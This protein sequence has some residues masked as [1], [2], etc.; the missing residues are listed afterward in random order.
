MCVYP[1]LV[2]NY[3]GQTAVLLA[4]PGL[5]QQAYWDSV[6]EA[7]REPRRMQ[8]A[9]A[10]PA[11]SQ[12]LPVAPAVHDVAYYARPA[13]VYWPMLV[14]A[15]IATV[16]ASQAL[17]T[18]SF[19]I[20]Q[21]AQALNVFPRLTIRHTSCHHK[22]QIYVPQVNWALMVGCVAVVAG[23]KTE[24]AIGHAYGAMQTS[25]NRNP[26][27]M[28]RRARPAMH[29]KSMQHASSR[30]PR[31]TVPMH[32]LNMCVSF[33][34]L[35]VVL[36]MLLSTWLATLCMLV[37]YNVHPLPAL[38]YFA[39]FT[40]AECA[41]LSSNAAKVPSGAWFPLV[42]TALLFSLAYI[43]H[44]GQSLK[45][46]TI[47]AHQQK[48][49]QLLAP[50]GG[51]KSMDGAAAPA[52]A[53]TAAQGALV[54]ADGTPVS[55]V[56]GVGIY[57]SELTGGVPPVMARF[58]TAVP[59]IHQVVVFL[60]VRRVPLP[61]VLEEEQLIL[62]K[63][64]LPGFYHAVLRAGYMDEVILDQDFEEALVEE[65]MAYLSSEV[66]GDAE[67][68]R[69]S[70]HGAGAREQGVLM[71]A[72]SMPRARSPYVRSASS[73]RALHRGRRPAGR[74]V[75]IDI[76]PG[77]G[78]EDDALARALSSLGAP[79]SAQAAGLRLTRAAAPPALQ[80]P[81][82]RWPGFCR[83]PL[84]GSRTRRRSRR[85][86][87]CHGCSSHR[88]TCACARC[89][90]AALALARAARS[91]ARCRCRRPP[92]TRRP[93]QPPRKRQSR[94]RA[95]TRRPCRLPSPRPQAAR[96]PPAPPP[97]APPPSRSLA[98]SS[99]AC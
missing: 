44:W 15:T 16:V 8:D 39:V 12:R 7:V 66:A 75:A 58:L 65:L 27:S 17:I 90:P 78:G 53:P 72:L 89:R 52:A 35:A 60:T 6:P 9:L 71:A 87:R 13:Q 51:R 41:F 91:P 62:R 37:T 81:S 3:L 73:L 46:A 34:G 29:S 25:R 38:V 31:P 23:F 69:G 45:S 20:A 56:P 55:R 14:I 4:R 28:R 74:S 59:A 33:A 1:S 50:A 18:G 48:L 63:L 93:R 11:S 42:V 5:V 43:W 84:W 57:F 61:T 32:F 86:V 24:E 2:L 40:F 98:K 95:W 47:A 30:T 82:G 64:S 79:L 88:C 80:R 76:E 96:P 77:A 49:H 83:S 85:R 19:T 97:S 26:C 92:G 68:Q 99:S 22:G 10:A 70:A 54:L 67:A 94:C 21:Q 36:V